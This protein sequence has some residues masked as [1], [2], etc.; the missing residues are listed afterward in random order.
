MRAGRRGPRAAA[1][2]GW[3]SRLGSTKVS[4]RW[5]A[6]R[7]P[8][9]IRSARA[10]RP[11]TFGTTP[12][13][14]RRRP[15]AT[16]AAVAAHGS[17]SLARSPDSGGGANSESGTR[18][19]G[20]GS[21]RTP[22]ATASEGRQSKRTGSAS[23]RSTTRLGSEGWGSRLLADVD[24]ARATSERLDRLLQRVMGHW[25]LRLDTLRSNG[26]CS[27]FGR[28]NPNRQPSFPPRS[29]NSI[30]CCWR[31]STSVWR[32]SS[33]TTGTNWSLI[34]ASSWPVRRR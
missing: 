3:A 18:I 26:D 8:A 21:H 6:R 34:G 22:S 29:R 17:L 25:P 23:S 24:A 13:A 10:W 9:N 28:T 5:L 14:E 16:S 33:N 20:G 30:T 1:A 19:S 2:G 12:D 15:I 7:R 32:I 31:P 27:R 11:A 4:S